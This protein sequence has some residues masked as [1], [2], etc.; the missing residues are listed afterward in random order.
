[1]LGKRGSRGLSMA[2]VAMLN[3]RIVQGAADR[4]SRLSGRGGQ[5]SGRN[6]LAW[7]HLRHP[8][9]RPGDFGTAIAFS[10]HDAA[11]VPPGFVGSVALPLAIRRC[12]NG[13]GT[14]GPSPRRFELNPLQPDLRARSGR[15]YGTTPVFCQAL[16]LGLDGNPTRERGSPTVTLCPSLT[17]RVSI[18]L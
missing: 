4:D 9:R 16:D 18:R 5:I 8:A 10:P 15:T 1:M 2:A 17:R 11:K 6:D 3:N 13:F 12:Q 14:G 7:H